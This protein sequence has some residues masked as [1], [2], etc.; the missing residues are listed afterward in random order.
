[1]STLIK[2]KI[3]KS[4]FVDVRKKYLWGVEMVELHRLLYCFF[5]C[6]FPD[7]FIIYERLGKVHNLLLLVEF[8]FGGRFRTGVKF[9]S[10][11]Q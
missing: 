3:Y 1:M 11:I 7:C 5:P 2:L 6:N 9:R 8:V 4:D 10:Y